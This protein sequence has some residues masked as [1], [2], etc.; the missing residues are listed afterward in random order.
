MPNTGRASSSRLSWRWARSPSAPHR[1]IYENVATV[2]QLLG[3]HATTIVATS[4]SG[5]VIMAGDRRATMGAM[6]A[7]REIEKVFPAD[8]YS[9][10]RLNETKSAG[11]VASIL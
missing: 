4:F 8:E 1:T 7:H 6:I 11:R 10:M 5:G 2:P 9:A 3:W